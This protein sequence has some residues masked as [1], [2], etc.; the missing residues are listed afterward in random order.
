MWGVDNAA[1]Y[2]WRTICRVHLGTPLLSVISIL[3]IIIKTSSKLIK[4]RAIIPPTVRSIEILLVGDGDG[5][6]DVSEGDNGGDD[7]GDGCDKDDGDG[8]DGDDGDGDDGVDQWVSGKFELGASVVIW[9]QF[10]FEL[11]QCSWWWFSTY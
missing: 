4:S 1:N 11:T 7:D 8:D 5:D 10:T 6:G 9:L 2:G 3:I